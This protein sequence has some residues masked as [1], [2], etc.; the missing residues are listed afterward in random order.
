MGRK[1]K[2]TLWLAMSLSL[3]LI[4]CRSGASLAEG[5]EETQ[6]TEPLLQ[7]KADREKETRF[8]QM[9]KREREIYLAGGCFWGV[10]AYFRQLPG[11]LDTEVGYAN[12]QSEETDYK[13]LAETGHA[14]TIRIRYDANRI[15]LAELILRFFTIIDP[16]SLN[17]QGNDVGKQYR[18]GIYYTNEKDLPILQVSMDW[19]RKQA[20]KPIAVEL[21]PLAHFVDAE[22]YHQDY[23]EKNPGGYCHINPGRAR[24]SLIDLSRY[25]KPE[26]RE[27]R[28]KLT[29]LQYEVTQNADT[30]APF[31]SVYEDEYGEGIYVDVV[32]GEPLFSSADKFDSGCGWPSFTQPLVQEVT[33]YHEDLSWGRVRTEVKSRVADSHLG[34]V[35]EDGP[36][37]LGSLRYCIN[38]A[39]LRF[40]PRARLEEYGYGEFEAFTIKQD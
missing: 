2:W 13:R 27:L 6:S 38:G 17:R 1:G 4:G 37:E 11:V 10:E 32:S 7:F 40:I 16:H 20:E 23:L 35:F 24:Q 36:S 28:E 18:T 19:Q 34:H 31:T 3:L 21:L 12:G 14:E 25:Q 5:T 26:D 22:A 30:E 39:A 15:H 29:P 33:N 9:P 8:D